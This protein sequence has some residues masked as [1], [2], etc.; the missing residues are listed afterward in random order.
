MNLLAKQIFA[1]FLLGTGV[2]SFFMGYLIYSTGV[3]ILGVAAVYLM[4]D[5]EES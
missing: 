1:G 3:L 4:L 5:E 2:T